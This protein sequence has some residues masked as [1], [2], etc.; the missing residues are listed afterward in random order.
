[1][2]IY[3]YTIANKSGIT[4]T[5]KVDAINMADAV[6][7]V[8]SN[9]YYIIEINE[10]KSRGLNILF[11]AD[12]RF[13]AFELIN[14]TDHLSSLMKA[15]TPLREALE[16][17]AEDGKGR[18]EMIDDIIKNIEQGIKLSAALSRHPSTFSPLYIAMVKAGEMAGNIDETL[19]YLANELRREHEFKQRVKSALFY[20]SLVLGVALL[21]VLLIVIVVVPKITEITKNMGADMPLATRIVASASNFLSHYGIFISAILISFTFIFIF[22]LKFKDT[23]DKISAYLL[24]APIT[25]KLM[26][27]YILARFL[28]IVG[29]CVKYGIP[30]AAAFDAAK[31]VVAN[32]TYREASIRIDQAV[33]KGISLSDAIS[34]EGIDIFP[35]IIARS[36]RGAEKTG[37]LDLALTRLSTQYEIEVDRDLKRL[38]EMI[39]PILV[40]FLGIIVLGIALAV[41]APIYQMTAKIK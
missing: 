19:E 1:M 12:K 27:K 22:F 24:K 32:R 36:I 11:S 6:S 7:L 20:P 25:G 16:A 14:F 17:Y 34:S 38:T 30:L 37:G 41:I 29:S 35:G 33:Q 28:R 5:G 10:L 21:V 9:G 15:G 26:R 31:D 8:K 39:E 2:S 13:S 23:K 3:T 18:M 40:V 4:K